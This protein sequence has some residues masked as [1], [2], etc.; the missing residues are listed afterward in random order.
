MSA[1]TRIIKYL[2]ELNGD[3]KSARG[4]WSPGWDSMIMIMVMVMVMILCI[5]P[6]ATGNIYRDRI[7][8]LLLIVALDSTSPIF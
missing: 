6:L 5:G 7:L 8:R 4:N 2:L 1:I 3:Y